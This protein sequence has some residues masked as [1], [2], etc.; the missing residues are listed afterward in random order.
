MP[1][2]QFLGYYARHLTSVEVNYTFRALPTET[3]LAGWLA[4]VDEAEANSTGAPAPHPNAFRF[5]FK[6]PETITHRRRLRDCDDALKGF[7]DALVPVEQAGRLG[8]LLFQLPPNFKADPER[9]ATFLSSSALQTRRD[10]PLRLAFE[11]RHPSWFAEETY[12]VLRA[13]D[14]ALCIAEGEDLVTPEVHTAA[15]F[16]CYRKRRSGAY[17]QA[18]LAEFAAQCTQIADDRETPREVYVYFRHEEQPTGAA[19]ALAF[20]AATGMEDEAANEAATKAG[21]SVSR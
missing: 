12:A 11:F 10:T 21:R 17:P 13:A 15:G 4:A 9:L 3:M 7:L 18:E 1:A 2:R 16:T 6:A 20:L 19:N 5:S 14:V 8:L